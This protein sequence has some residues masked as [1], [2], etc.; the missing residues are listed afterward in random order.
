[1]NQPLYKLVSRLSRMPQPRR[2]MSCVGGNCVDPRSALKWERE[3]P[4][5]IAIE[6]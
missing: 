2:V 6:S 3:P 5:P 1:M 4:V